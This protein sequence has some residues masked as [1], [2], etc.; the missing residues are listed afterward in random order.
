MLPYQ[1]KLCK[2]PSEGVLFWIS[3]CKVIAKWQRFGS[4]GDHP[5]WRNLEKVLEPVEADYFRALASGVAKTD[6]QIRYVRTHLWWIGNDPKRRGKRH[7]LSEDH[8]KNL[9]ELEK[10][11]SPEGEGG[12]LLKAEALRELSRFE[13]ALQL[14]DYEFSED[15]QHTSAIIRDLAKKS[16]PALV[17]VN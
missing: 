17:E 15:Y 16:D 6:E 7:E 4:K 12:R 14:L 5:E 13:E 3:D 8:L 9:T 2:S 1:H 10:T 11:L